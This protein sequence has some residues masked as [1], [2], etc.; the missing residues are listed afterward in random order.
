M[1]FLPSELSGTN[2]LIK[3]LIKRTVKGGTG[4][5]SYDL[6]FNR[7]PGQDVGPWLLLHLELRHLPL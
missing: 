7:M 2:T 1:P 5:T 3:N 4:G 6:H